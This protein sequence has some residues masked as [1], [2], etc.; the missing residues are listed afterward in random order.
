MPDMIDQAALARFMDEAAIRNTIARFAD[1]ATRGDGEMFR[2]LWTKDAEFIIGQ[3]PRQ[4]SA[5]GV[6]DVVAMLRRLRGGRDFF[7]QFAVP[8]VIDIEGD[9]ATTRTFCHEAARGPGETFYRNHCVAFDRLRR[10]N[11]GWAFASRSF[12]YLW[13]DTSP[14]A[15]NGFPLFPGDASPATGSAHGSVAN[16]G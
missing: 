8:G 14:F 7:V 10:T 15:G 13:L 9:E 1:S 11:E 6:D 5:K 3:A 16:W 2:T 12:Q 4:Q